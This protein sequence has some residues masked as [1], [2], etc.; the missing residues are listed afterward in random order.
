MGARPTPHREALEHAL[1]TLADAVTGLGLHATIT[2]PLALSVRGD[3]PAP[4]DLGDGVA[5]LLEPT[6]PLSQSVTIESRGGRLWWCWV[7]TDAERG[8]HDSEPI[9][10]VEE[11]DEVARRIRTVVA[12]PSAT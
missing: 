2:G 4:D 1:R 3:A 9:L 12:L 5:R 8:G 11:V 7:W 10:P 6:A